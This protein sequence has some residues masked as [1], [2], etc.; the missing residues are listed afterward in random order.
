MGGELIGWKN[1]L[2]LMSYGPRFRNFRRLAH[3]LFGNNA[4]MKPFFTD[5]G[6]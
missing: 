6:A 2:G 1:S 4:T 3:Q 5:G